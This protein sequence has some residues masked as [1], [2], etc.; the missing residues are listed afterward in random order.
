MSTMVQEVIVDGEI[1]AANVSYE[2]ACEQRDRYLKRGANH[3]RLLYNRGTH[4][5]SYVFK[6]INNYGDNNGDG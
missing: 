3:V 1:K 2:N 5:S 6:N 4:M